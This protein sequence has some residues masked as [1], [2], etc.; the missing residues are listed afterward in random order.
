MSTTPT[1]TAAIS[2]EI[3]EMPILSDDVIEKYID[4][5]KEINIKVNPK[6]CCPELVDTNLTVDAGCTNAKCGK[7]LDTVQG[8][9]I[10]TYMNCNNT[11]RVKKILVHVQLCVTIWK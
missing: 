1:T 2:D 11:T 10:V 5:K 8:E 3:E 4:H 7:P 9:R 6:I